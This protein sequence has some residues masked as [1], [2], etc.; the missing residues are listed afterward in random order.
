MKN[1]KPLLISL[2]VIIAVFIGLILVLPRLKSDDSETS[3]ETSEVDLTKY[4]LTSVIEGNADNGGISD[5][6]LGSVDAPVTIYEYADYQCSACAMMKP[7]VVD[8]LLEEFSGKI[9]IVYRSFP[10]TSLHPNAIAAASAAEA[11][12]LQGFWEEYASLLFSNQSEWFYATGTSRTNL[13]MS[14]F[15]SVAGDNGDLAKFRADMASTNVKKK[16][17]FDKSIA[18]FYKLDGTPSFIGEDGKEVEWLLDPEK[19]TMNETLNHFRK[20][21]NEKLEEKGIK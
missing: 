17:N 1:N 12:G 14:Y 19:Q 5:H 6:I 11:A 4:N 10:L 16:V 13:F 9:R 8:P 18:E 3:G 21:I 15:T 7:Y 2:I 20:Y